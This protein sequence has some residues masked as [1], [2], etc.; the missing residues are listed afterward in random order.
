MGFK[1]YTHFE[2]KPYFACNV[3]AK[4]NLR[5]KNELRCKVDYFATL[6]KS[7]LCNDKLDV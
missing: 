7:M 6:S 1:H 5:C 2:W 3:R 4:I